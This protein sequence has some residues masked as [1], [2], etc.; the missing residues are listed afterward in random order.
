MTRFIVLFSA[1]YSNHHSHDAPKDKR[2]RRECL[3]R[4]YHLTSRLQVDPDHLQKGL[5]DFQEDS[6]CQR[7]NPGHLQ[8]GSSE[9]REESNDL[10]QEDGATFKRYLGSY[11]RSLVTSKEIFK[12]DRGFEAE[13]FVL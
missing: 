6:S 2:K 9:Q 7:N 11:K 3:Y 12:R 8:K 5:C 13:G 10:L 1:Y 4:T